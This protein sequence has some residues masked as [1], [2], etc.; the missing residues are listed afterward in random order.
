MRGLNY[1]EDVGKAST[2]ECVLQSLRGSFI[3]LTM[4][5]FTTVAHTVHAIKN[6]SFHFIDNKREL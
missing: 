3:N 4:M 1:T 6:D 5:Y 2:W